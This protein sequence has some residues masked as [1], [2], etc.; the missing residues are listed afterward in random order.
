[1]NNKAREILRDHCGEV[2]NEGFFIAAMEEY[3]KQYHNERPCL[4]FSALDVQNETQDEGGFINFA[5]GRNGWLERWGVNGGETVGIVRGHDGVI[6]V[7]LPQYIK[8]VE[9]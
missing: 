9:I 4:F 5:R 1:M 7:V 6:H 8:I 2:A 3:A